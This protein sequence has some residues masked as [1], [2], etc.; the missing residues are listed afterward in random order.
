MVSI[1]TNWGAM[2]VVDAHLYG[3]VAGVAADN[4]QSVA[5]LK[6]PAHL[7][8]QIQL[9]A[10]TALPQQHIHVVM[11]T[12]ACTTHGRMPLWV[13]LAGTAL[14]H[15]SPLNASIIIVDLIAHT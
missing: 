9:H 15:I 11:P 3:H 6:A 14:Q 13:F 4:D 10:R 2:I 8:L 5:P 12:R 7:G 1:S